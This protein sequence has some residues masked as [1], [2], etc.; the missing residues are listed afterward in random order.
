MVNLEETQLPTRQAEMVINRGPFKD[1]YSKYRMEE[2][3]ESKTMEF[4]K[5]V[6]VDK[7]NVIVKSCT[8]NRNAPAQLT[9]RRTVI[10]GRRTCKKNSQ[11][12]KANTKVKVL[13]VYSNMF[14]P[15]Q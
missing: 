11:L 3:N 5:E 15:K 14:C 4:E 6:D 8:G 2:T 12:I 9:C 13:N 1:S 7:E 10:R